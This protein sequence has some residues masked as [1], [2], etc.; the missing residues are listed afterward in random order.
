MAPFGVCGTDLKTHLRGY[1]HIQPGSVTDY[2]VTRV[3]AESTNPDVQTGQR[4][5]VAQY[6]PCG[7]CRSCRRGDP[8]PGQDRGGAC[9]SLAASLSTSA[10]PEHL[11]T[12][13]LRQIA[14]GMSFALGRAGRATRLL[15]PIAERPA[16]AAAQHA[17]DH[18]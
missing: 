17:A 9:A 16:S 13:G 2:K 7:E 1:T 4:V 3:V 8:S 12:L 18:R 6:A 14:A 15:H 11:V 10:S 5:P